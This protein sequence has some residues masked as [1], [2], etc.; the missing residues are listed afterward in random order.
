MK[1]I[2]LL[3]LSLA[4][5]TACERKID[6]Y[7]VTSGSANFTKY[8][9]VG[10]SLFAGYADGALYHNAQKNSIPSLIAGQLQLAGAGAFV[11]PVVNSEYGVEFPGSRPKLKLGNSVNC[12]NEVSLAPVPDLGPRDPLLPAVG[13]A[14]NNFGIPG[15]KSFHA[16]AAHYGDPAGLATLPPSSNPYY[17]RFSLTPASSV[18]ADV[19]A[20]SPTFFTLW[21]GDNDVLSYALSGG[22]GDTLTSPGFFQTAMGGVVTALTSTGAKGVISNIPDITA[23]PFFT[24]IPYN[25]LYLSRQSLVDSINYFMKTIFHLPDTN[26]KLGYNPFL[27]ADTSAPNYFKVRAMK[28][29]EYVLMSVPQDSLKCGGWG[30]ISSSLFI[31]YG[32]PDQFILTETEVS[33]IT[34]AT[35]AYNQIISGLSSTFGLGLVDMN[36]HMKELQSGISWNGISMNTKFVSGGAFSLDGIHLTSRG[37][38]L[39]ANFFIDVINSKFGSTIPHVDVT[40]YP[41]VLFP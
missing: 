14:V 6:E 20:G 38:A 35:A 26:Y 39:A 32:I 3:I 31:P 41:G 18:V 19:L 25:G 24:T 4:F 13:Y 9:A 10:N 37:N 28:P 5:F 34:A 2:F 8:V 21:L 23:I 33:Q 16:L 12:L 1:K 27:I 22:V 7:S 15:M 36:A 40:R 29:G 11:Q 17:V 30:I